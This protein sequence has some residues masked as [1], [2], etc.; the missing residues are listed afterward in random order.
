MLGSEERVHETMVKFKRAELVLA[1]I[2]DPSSSMR[3]RSRAYALGDSVEEMSEIPALELRAAHI[4]QSDAC[5][6]ILITTPVAFWEHGAPFARGQG[7]Y[8][9]AFALD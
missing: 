1:P 8:G 5:R 3:V 2:P 4:F 6:Q 9:V 7:A